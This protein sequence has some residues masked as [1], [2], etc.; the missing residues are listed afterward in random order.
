MLSSLQQL[1]R[2]EDGRRRGLRR[3][4]LFAGRVHR[5]HIGLMTFSL[6]PIHTFFPHRL[7]I[8]LLLAYTVVL[9]VP[10][11]DFVNGVRWLVSLQTV[12]FF[13]DP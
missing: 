13:L 3:G 11:Y 2:Y 5:R 8:V 12:E 7:S 6:L 9:G 1:L 10:C 4:G